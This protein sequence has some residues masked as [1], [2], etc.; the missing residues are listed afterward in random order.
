MRQKRNLVFQALDPLDDT[1]PL[2]TPAPWV[3]SWSRAC[4]SAP[5]RCGRSPAAAGTAGLILDEYVLG[6]SIPNVER[7][8]L[9]PVGLIVVASLL[10]PALE[11]QRGR[12][13]GT[14]TRKHA[15]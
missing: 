10:P 2:T 1:R 9:P 13:K 3:C 11:L 7:C 15:P 12:R 6:T 14:R 5:S 4:P 8:P